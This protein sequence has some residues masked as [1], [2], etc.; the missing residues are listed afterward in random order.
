M[1]LSSKIIGFGLLVLLGLILA[2]APVDRSARPQVNTK[3]LLAE[4][5]QRNF[6][7]SP[8]DL[9][10]KIIDKEPGFV[11]VDVRSK[12]DYDKYHIPGS[13]HVPLNELLSSEQLKDLAQ[14]NAIILTSNGNSM[15]A[16]AWLLLRQNGFDDVYILSGGM[17]YWVQAFSHPQ[18]PKGAYT[19]DELF[20]YE[21]RKAAG[22]VMMG[23][24]FVHQEDKQEVKIRKPVI[25]KRHKK[26]KQLD[27][28]C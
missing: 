28:G 22:P 8:E 11:V 10:H 13:I 6:Y 17:N 26:T 16:Q 3:A 24:A 9:A 20:R 21:F 1:K 12:E 25:R 7:V 4:L 18:P 5:Q 19:D 2:F 27:E 15:A 23:K 14:D